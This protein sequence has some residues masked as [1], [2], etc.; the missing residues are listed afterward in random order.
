MIYFVNVDPGKYL[1]VMARNTTIFFKLRHPLS[2]KCR[3]SP[4]DATSDLTGTRT[5]FVNSVEW[6][7]Y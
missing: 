5:K 1:V 4:S 6:P 7:K 2:V 3:Q